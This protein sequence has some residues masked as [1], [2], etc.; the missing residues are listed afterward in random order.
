MSL[1][2]GIK[3]VAAFESS[4]KYAPSLP[5]PRGYN[6]QLPRVPNYLNYNPQI[7]YRTQFSSV[8]QMY[9]NN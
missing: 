6:G 2:P 4:R 1:T 5:V 7:S 3:Y 8:S 9:K